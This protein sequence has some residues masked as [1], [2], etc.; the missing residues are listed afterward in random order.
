M[1]RYRLARFWFDPSGVRRRAGIVYTAD[2]SFAEQ[3][4]SGTEILDDK[5]QVIEVVDNRPKAQE[6]KLVTVD[7]TADKDAKTEVEEKT[8][9]SSVKL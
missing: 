6:K 5:N 1:L 2:D 3:L 4:P 9:K 7:V 8:T